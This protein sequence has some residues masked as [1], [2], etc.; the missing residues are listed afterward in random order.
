MMGMLAWIF[1]ILG[2]LCA[3]MGI[4]TAAEVMDPLG[5][6]FTTM[7]WFV[8]SVILLLATIAFAVSESKYE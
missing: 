7:F 1:G 6:G 2:G 5:A 4:I 3:I 8:L